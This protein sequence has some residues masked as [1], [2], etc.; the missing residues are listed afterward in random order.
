MYAFS[1]P[2][3]RLEF[4]YLRTS[5]EE[6]VKR[7]CT[8]FLVK[9]KAQTDINNDIF[10]TSHDLLYDPQ[11]WYST[12][13]RQGGGGVS[14]ELDQEQTLTTGMLGLIAGESIL[15]RKLF[16]HNMRSPSGNHR[17]FVKELQKRRPIEQRL[18]GAFLLQISTRSR[19]NDMILHHRHGGGGVSPELTQ[20][21][22]WQQ[23][24]MD[25]LQ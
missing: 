12:S 24:S 19:S 13:R 14:Q 1:E 9:D 18:V 22:H 7:V 3:V 6:P 21:Q 20:E 2:K 4:P 25:I 23:V 16:H 15:V 5:K 8:Y 17:I 10:R 11:K